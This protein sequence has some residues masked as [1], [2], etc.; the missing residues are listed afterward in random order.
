MNIYLYRNYLEW[1]KDEPYES[2]DGNITIKSGGLV[3]IE[4][5]ENYKSYKQILSFEKLFAIVYKLPYNYISFPREINVFETM[6]SW[7]DSI[8][9]VSFTGEIQEDECSDKHVTFNTTDGFKQILSLSK[10]F[11]VSYES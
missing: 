11:A 10:I 2:L 5:V 1:E 3:I 6:D 7:C 8:S 4:T 9:Q